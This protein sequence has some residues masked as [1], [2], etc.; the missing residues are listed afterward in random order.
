[1]C[2]PGGPRCLCSVLLFR[3]LYCQLTMWSTATC[4]SLS[5]GPSWIGRTPRLYS[6]TA[7]RRVRRVALYVCSYPLH[8][9]TSRVRTACK[10]PGTVLKPLSAAVPLTAVESLRGGP[11]AIRQAGSSTK[12]I[13]EQ[14]RISLSTSTQNMSTDNDSSKSNSDIIV[15]TDLEEHP[16][17]VDKNPAHFE[18]FLHEIAEYCKRTGHFISLVEQRAVATASTTQAC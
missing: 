8:A 15:F 13:S 12:L 4:V 9:H 3:L 6:P 16:I 10:L 18:G 14:P 1:M 5:I 7:V 2:I 11:T 17:T